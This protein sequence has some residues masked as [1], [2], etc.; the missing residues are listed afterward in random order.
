VFVSF[1]RLFLKSLPMS[2]CNLILCVMRNKYCKFHRG[3]VDNT[4][5]LEAFETF[6]CSSYHE[7]AKQLQEAATCFTPIMKLT[8]VIIGKEDDKQNKVH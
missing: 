5:G 6:S 2:A 4:C 8:G 3:L 7:G 1:R